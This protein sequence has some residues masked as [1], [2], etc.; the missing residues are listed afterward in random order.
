L[1]VKRFI[2][3]AFVNGIWLRSKAS[4]LTFNRPMSPLSLH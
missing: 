3:D 4:R 1:L 2:S